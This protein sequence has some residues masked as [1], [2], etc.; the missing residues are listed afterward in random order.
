[1]YF[2]EASRDIASVIA[3]VAGALIESRLFQGY[4]LAS[5][6]YHW[7]NILRCTYQSRALLLNHGTRQQ[8][9]QLVEEKKRK[10]PL[11]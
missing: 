9:A 8:G 6:Q 5:E 4:S 11:E 3:T 7:T 2:P 1:M 10:E